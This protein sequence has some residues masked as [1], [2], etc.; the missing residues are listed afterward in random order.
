MPKMAVA[1]FIRSS[2]LAASCLLAGSLAAPAA[3]AHTH[4]EQSQPAANAAVLAPEQIELRFTEVLIERFAKLTL[5]FLGPDGRAKAQEVA[6]LKLSL[7]AD[8]QGLIATP[9][10]P[11]AAGRYRVEWRVVSADTHPVKGKF[12][13]TVK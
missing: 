2:S 10:A 4:L 7:S 3:W 8:Q 6:G 13:F 11:L 5:Q 12:E 9:A 1:R